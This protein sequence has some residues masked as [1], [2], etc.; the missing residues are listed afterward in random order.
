MIGDIKRK[1]RTSSTRIN[2]Q[3]RKRKATKALSVK[4]TR[5]TTK[6]DATKVSPD[7]DDDYRASVNYTVSTLN[8][9]SKGFSLGSY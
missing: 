6:L 4:L 1:K 7:S 5:S 2:R 9:I 3:R 8:Y